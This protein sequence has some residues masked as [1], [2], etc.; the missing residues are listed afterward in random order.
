MIP[1]YD[2]NLR[3]GCEDCRNANV[4][5]QDCRHGLLF[6]VLAVMAGYEMCPN[7]EKKTTEQLEEQL[8]TRAYEREKDRNASEGCSR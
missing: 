4:H 5:G 6:P 1:H 2:I 3:L 7:F 8:R